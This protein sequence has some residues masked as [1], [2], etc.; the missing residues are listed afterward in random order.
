MS[1]RAITETLNDEKLPPL[2]DCDEPVDAD[3]NKGDSSRRL[4][5]RGRKANTTSANTISSQSGNDDESMISTLEFPTV[6]ANATT[7]RGNE[8]RGGRRFGKRTRNR[9]ASMG[10]ETAAL[11]ANSRA[12][13]ISQI[14]D[15]GTVSGGNKQSDQRLSA[16]SSGPNSGRPNESTASRR[17]SRRAS[18]SSVPTTVTSPSAKKPYRVAAAFHG[19]FDIMEQCNESKPLSTKTLDTCAASSFGSAASGEHR[20]QMT[21]E[22]LANATTVSIPR[23][24]DILR[25]YD[26]RASKCASNL[27]QKASTYEDS[28][29]G[30]ASE[31]LHSMSSRMSEAATILSAVSKYL[32]TGSLVPT[33]EP[34]GAPKDQTLSC[35]RQQRRRST[36]DGYAVANIH[37]A[38]PVLAKHV[39]SHHLRPVNKNSRTEGRRS[40]VGGYESK[41]VDNSFSF[42]FQQGHL[43]H[44]PSGKV[45]NSRDENHLKSVRKEKRQ[46]RRCSTGSTYPQQLADAVK[47]PE[48]KFFAKHIDSKHL[49]PMKTRERQ[50]RRF[51]A[52]GGSPLGRDFP[53]IM[54]MPSARSI[55][56]AGN[57]PGQV[58]RKSTGGEGSLSNANAVA[59]DI[60]PRTH[61]SSMRSLKEET[62]E[63]SLTEDAHQLL[64]TSKQSPNRQHVKANGAFSTICSKP[65]PMNDADDTNYSGNEKA[66]GSIFPLFRSFHPREQK[67]EERYLD[68]KRKPRR[69]LLRETEGVC[70]TKIKTQQGHKDGRSKRRSQQRRSS[71][72]SFPVLDTYY[73]DY[74]RQVVVDDGRQPSG[75]AAEKPSK[76]KSRARKSRLG[77]GPLL[78]Q[79]T[80][81]AARK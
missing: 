7:D 13:W 52:G 54:P 8:H 12:T 40:S 45:A 76:D 67:G 81:P 74:Q 17:V 19:R 32:E 31:S 75:H 63:W 73:D 50:E 4:S 16:Q 9:R 37:T 56:I 72:G 24:C 62:A 44:T 71:T 36:G 39:D 5:S 51:S 79:N 6:S 26:S 65:P 46:Q 66:K 22:P 53:P 35:R 11:A 60:Q 38:T 3:E 33:R 47:P 23:R 68:T 20:H 21:I 15:L 77:L 28:T 78:S 42:D 49:R 64:A 41:L 57:K 29:N 27:K 48:K 10:S 70:E 25:Q 55:E 30:H 69:S 80:K 1:Q 61:H 58:R 59:I 14:F 43:A 2:V 18:L 34:G